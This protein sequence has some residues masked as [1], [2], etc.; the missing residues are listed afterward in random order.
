MR[1]VLVIGI[2]VQFIGVAFQPVIIA[3][4]SIESDKSELVEITVEIYEVN[5]VQE[6]TVMLSQEQAEELELLINKTKTEL[7]AADNSDETENIF[8]NTV[9]S[10]NELGLLTNEINVEKVQRLV[11]G[12]EQNPRVVKLFEKYYSKNQKNLDYDKNILCLI[13]GGTIKTVFIAP[14]ALLFGLLFGLHGPL[15]FVRHIKFL[16][17]FNNI[18]PDLLSWWLE[19]FGE[20]HYRLLFLRMSFWIT[21]GVGLN[22]LPLKIGAYIHYGWFKFYFYPWYNEVEDIPAEGWVN[23]YG[24]FGK[25][26]WSGDFYGGVIGFTGIKITN[27]LL[28]HFYFGAALGVSIDDERI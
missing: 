13:A 4:V 24:L 20:F 10:L 19:N 16:E 1:E 3:D 17:W 9:L 27:K 21:F 5:R 18:N 11:R 6:Y 2:I 25:K 28:D 23:T 8:M 14:F 15:S 12:E 22:F 7:D 26:E